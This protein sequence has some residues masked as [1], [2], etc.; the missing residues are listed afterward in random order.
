MRNAKLNNL[1]STDKNY[2]QILHNFHSANGRMKK[3]ERKENRHLS[4]IL[5]KDFWNLKIKE[6]EKKRNFKH[7]PVLKKIYFFLPDKKGSLL[8]IMSIK[9]KF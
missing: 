7:S 2:Q 9:R 8:R 1:S 3:K 6:K 4:R 5:L